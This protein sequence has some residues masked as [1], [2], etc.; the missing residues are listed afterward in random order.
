MDAPLK[1]PRH[2]A[3]IMDGN[4]RWAQSRGL[5]RV[6]GHEAG[7]DSVREIVRACRELGCEAVTLY[8]FST[9]NW[10]RP[11]QEVAAL[12]ALLRRYL[13]QERRELVDNGVR[14]QAIGSHRMTLTLALSYGGRAEIVDAVQ[15]IAKKVQEG[16][17]R[18][19]EIDDTLLSQHLF[20][21]ALPDPDLLIRT[22]GE[23]RIS[24]FMLWQLAY[25]EIY[26]TETA[27]PDFRRPQLIEA[28]RD[29]SARERRF[30]KT[31]AQVQRGDGD[32]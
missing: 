16:R 14:F 5:P 27:W 13:V 24:N 6:K 25:S 2:V 17:L 11:P 22:S 8:S 23:M 15:R 20:T 21:A 12:M 31:A 30:G 26:V 29:Y 4:G 3:I 1:V 9:E 10:S 19:D 32:A 28:F 7:A 18:P